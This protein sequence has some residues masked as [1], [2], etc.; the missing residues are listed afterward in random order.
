MTRI[1]APVL[2]VLVLFACACYVGINATSDGYLRSNAERSV[3]Q[4]IAEVLRTGQPGTEKATAPKDHDP[5]TSPDSQNPANA[6]DPSDSQNTDNAADPQNPVNQRNRTENSYEI[7]RVL[8]DADGTVATHTAGKKYSEE[9]ETEILQLLEAGNLSGKPTEFSIAGRNYM[10]ASCTVPATTQPEQQNDPS[11]IAV[12]AQPRQQSDTAK[13]DA[14]VQQDQSS[15]QQDQSSLQAN[16]AQTNLPAQ[17][18]SPAQS[19]QPNQTSNANEFAQSESQAQTLIVYQE[20]PEGSRVLGRMGKLILEITLLF[21]ALAVVLV[22]FI[23]RSIAR[24]IEELCQKTAAIGEENSHT[25]AEENPQ[26]EHLREV[27]FHGAAESKASAEQAA[28]SGRKH[29]TITELEALNAS[30]SDMADRID[31]NQ[32]ALRAQAETLAAQR[33]QLRVQ[34]E[35]LQEQQAKLIENQRVKERIFQNISHDL[36]TPLVSIIGYADGLYRG[37]IS[38]QQIV[39]GS[40]TGTDQVNRAE[41]SDVQVTGATTGTGRVNCDER[42]DVRTAAGVILREGRRMQRM[43]ESS[44]TLTKLNNGGWKLQLMEVPV[45]ELIAEQ[46]EA[47]KKY[48]PEKRLVFLNEAERDESEEI[49]RET[50]LDDAAAETNHNNREFILQTDP[51]LLIR[52]FGNIVS[53]CLRY[54]ESTVKVSIRE[55]STKDCGVREENTRDCGMREANTEGK[56]LDRKLEID[57][58]VIITVRDDGPGIA[59]EDLPH[60]FEEYYKGKDGSFGIGLSVVSSGVRLLGGTVR[61]YNQTAPSHGAVYEVRLPKS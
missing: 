4:A 25:I 14:S 17:A 51:D 46:V 57:D 60:I 55:V 28:D 56:L 49:L 6:A 16:T 32:A 30:I 12:S 8:V 23:A 21:F 5:N 13:T 20:I 61:A 22:W 44:L 37:T 33:D 9:F 35:T 54:A 47:L 36:R 29:Y 10:V 2:L 41:Y 48:A 27:D 24:P 11:T 31:R 59:E 15:L 42:S 7:Q 18:D 39:E 58:F 45:E 26:A 40:L 19:N 38:D 50:D 3:H 52:I 53:D 1:L 43:L 34:T